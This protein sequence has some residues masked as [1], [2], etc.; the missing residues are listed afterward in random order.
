MGS[1]QPPTPLGRDPQEAIR[2]HL[3]IV[4]SPNGPS[5]FNLETL[6]VLRARRRLNYQVHHVTVKNTEGE[7]Q[8]F[9]FLV[10]RLPD[11]SW[12]VIR[13]IGFPPNSQRLP[14]VRGDLPTLS[15]SAGTVIGEERSAAL[16]MRARGEIWKLQLYLRTTPGGAEKALALEKTLQERLEAVAEAERGQEA[17]KVLQEVQELAPQE[18]AGEE[19][20]N[21]LHYCYVFGEVVANGL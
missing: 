10:C 16:L 18:L 14:P 4:G 21:P 19:L 3:H 1:F 20:W 12:L 13:W 5:I 17:W 2:Q 9:W 11:D 15:F 7:P 8:Q 6:H